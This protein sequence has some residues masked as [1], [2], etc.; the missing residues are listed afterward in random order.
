MSHPDV[1]VC[2][3]SYSI[4]FT[5]TIIFKS[6]QILKSESIFKESIQIFFQQ[7][8]SRFEKLEDEI[9]ELEKQGSPDA[10]KVR[11]IV[12]MA[13]NI[14]EQTEVGSGSARKEIIEILDRAEALVKASK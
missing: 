9:E 1:V 3:F 4:D 10:F 11:L 14:F 5:I 7:C 2:E 12:K 8:E 13:R 6:N